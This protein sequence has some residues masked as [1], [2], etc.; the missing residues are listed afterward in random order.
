M[1]DRLNIDNV[2]DCARIAYTLWP[3]TEK[4]FLTNKV[5]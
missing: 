1:I 2:K 3:E 5:V 4:R